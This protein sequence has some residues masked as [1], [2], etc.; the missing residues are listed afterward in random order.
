M[1]TFYV[2]VPVP[3]LKKKNNNSSLVYNWNQITKKNI[4]LQVNLMNWWLKTDTA[5][6]RHCSNIYEKIK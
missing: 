6:E 1:C 3:H 5:F 4:Y 2:R